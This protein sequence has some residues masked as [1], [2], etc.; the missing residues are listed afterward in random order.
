MPRT[1]VL[2]QTRRHVGCAHDGIYMYV[3]KHAIVELRKSCS[4]LMFQKKRK[5]ELD[6]VFFCWYIRLLLQK[7]RLH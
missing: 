6:F 1:Q 3:F 7:A 5:I 4:M 2:M